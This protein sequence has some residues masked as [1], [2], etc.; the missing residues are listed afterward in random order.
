MRPPTR[1]SGRCGSKTR[2]S[3]AGSILKPPSS[4]LCAGSLPAR[5]AR[6]M[7]PLHRALRFVENEAQKH[8]TRLVARFAK[9]MGRGF[10][11]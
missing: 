5:M 8:E 9:L 11:A 6:Q 7:S 3:S 2:D 1:S 10:S 4:F